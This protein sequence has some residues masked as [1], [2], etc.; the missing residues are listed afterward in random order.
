M[1]GIRFIGRCQLHNFRL[2]IPQFYCDI[3][4]FVVQ[5]NMLDRDRT[6]ALRSL[7]DSDPHPSMEPFDGFPWDTTSTAEDQT[8]RQALSR[9]RDKVNHLLV[10]YVAT[11][12]SCMY[13]STLQ[14][15]SVRHCRFPCP[16]FMTSS[17]LNAT[18]QMAENFLA[19]RS[20]T[21]SRIP[22]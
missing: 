19:V 6:V 17:V 15:R 4:K 9:F 10:L 1:A 11:N 18:F 12:L 16:P 20:A 8:L 21:S 22:R 2:E 13:D 3:Y 5:R 14:I 7:E